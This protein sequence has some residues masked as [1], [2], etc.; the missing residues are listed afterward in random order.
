VGLVNALDA[1]YTEH[2]SY[3]RDPFRLG[4][5]VNEPGRSVFVNVAAR[6]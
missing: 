4:V 1:T 2:L 6:F 3:Y 5:R